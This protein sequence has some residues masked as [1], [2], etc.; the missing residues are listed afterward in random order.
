MTFLKNIL[1]LFLLIFNAWI[2]KAEYSPADMANVNIANR[3]DYVADPANLLNPQTKEQVNK[4]LWDIRQTTSA[5]VVVA[6]PPDIGDTPIEDW[7]EQLFTSWGIGKRDRDNGLLL[8]IAPAQRTAR[9]QTGY[10]LEGILTDISCKKIINHQIVPHMKR[11]DL[12]GAVLAAV[13][14]I[15]DVLTDPSAAQELRSKEP[16]AWEY[17]AKTLNPQIFRNFIITVVLCVFIFSTILFVS[18]LI[19]TRKMGSYSK[20]IE[21]RKSINL[22]TWTAIASAGAGVIYLLL[23]FILYRYFRT[24]PKKCDTCGAK[25][26]RLPEDKDNELLSDK[27]DLE[28][29]LNTIDYDVWECPQCGTIERFPFVTKQ[30]KYTECPNCHTVAMCLDHEIIERRPTLNHSG[31]KTKIYECRY[32]HHKKHVSVVIPKK[33]TPPIIIPIGGGGSGSSGFGGGFGGGSTGG[34]GASGGW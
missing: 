14:K 6:L 26:H 18:R 8:V 19:K 17:G 22:F 33:E 1:L 30:N 21:W 3:Y 11:N 9:L 16:D 23:A 29:K 34:G 13:T 12:D 7:S 32:C 24:K 5:E 15:H 27:Q 20:S 25:M 4:I 31:K 10:G 28:E 2:A